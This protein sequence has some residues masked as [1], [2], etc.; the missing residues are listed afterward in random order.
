MM[1]V[2]HMVAELL[3]GF[4]TGWLLIYCAMRALRD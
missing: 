1:T 4:G 3:I 2:W